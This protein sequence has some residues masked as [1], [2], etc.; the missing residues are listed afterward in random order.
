MT[1]MII[2]NL[3]AA[4][5]QWRLHKARL[6]GRVFLA[7]NV[8]DGDYEKPAVHI[9]ALRNIRVPTQ[10]RKRKDGQ[11]NYG[12]TIFGVNELTSVVTAEAC[13]CATPTTVRIL[14]FYVWL[15][16]H[17]QHR[18]QLPTCSRCLQTCTRLTGLPIDKIR[19][20]R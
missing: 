11:K 9:L 6:S 19:G 15:E 10:G 8:D 2:S 12:R 14:R 7:T 16:R 4:L 18:Y 17:R 5:E 3:G 1:T 20:V 13:F